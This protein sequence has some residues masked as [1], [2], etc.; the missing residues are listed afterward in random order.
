MN[1]IVFWSL[2]LIFKI[3]ILPAY[4]QQ[5]VSIDTKL[6]HLAKI[7]SNYPQEKV[8][9]HTDKPYYVVGDDIWLKAYIVVAEKNEFSKLSKVL[10]IDLI[11]ENK[12]IKKSV[13]LPIENGVAHG[14]ITLVDS[15]NEGSYSIR[16]YT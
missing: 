3:A 7:T 10:Y 8:H 4:A 6:K 1:K 11:D 9:L 16:A 13:T 14:N 15:L 12:T 2:I 5:L